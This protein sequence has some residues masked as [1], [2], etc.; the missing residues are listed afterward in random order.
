MFQRRQSLIRSAVLAALAGHAGISYGQ[1]AG[2]GSTEL[3]EVIVTGIR[4]S[5]RAS[6]ETKREETAIVDA[7]TAEDVTKFPDKNLAESLSRVPG[8]QVSETGSAADLSTASVRG[9]TSAQTPVYLAGIR[10]NDD[11]T[12]TADLSLIPLWMLGR[13]EVYRGNA[14]ADADR[15]GIGGAIY[16]EPRLPRKNRLLAGAQVGSF[17]QRALWLGAE[18]ARG[19]DAGEMRRGIDPGL[20]LDLRHHAQRA[21]TRRAAGAVGHRD[22]ARVE[23][24]E[25]GH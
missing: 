15:L 12:G 24:R 17:G 10:L 4:S 8:V 18:V 14:P 25:L 11:L 6:L 20:R 19:G 13:A 16:F 9:A 7:I 21:L 23:R 5:Y 1:Q 22:E 3:E 2:P